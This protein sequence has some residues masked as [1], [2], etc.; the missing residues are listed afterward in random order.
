[1]RLQGN[2]SLS[3]SVAFSLIISTEVK[4]KTRFIKRGELREKQR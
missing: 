1:V 2:F 3:L 4:A